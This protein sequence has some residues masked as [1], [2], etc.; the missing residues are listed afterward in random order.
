MA[1]LSMGYG[2]AAMNQ[3]TYGCVQ[4]TIG[5]GVCLRMR[6]GNV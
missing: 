4:K 1:R 2:Q 5:Y 6:S 3:A